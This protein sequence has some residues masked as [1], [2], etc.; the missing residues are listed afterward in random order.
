MK[1]KNVVI[2]ILIFIALLSFSCRKDKAESEVFSSNWSASVD[3]T[4]VGPDFWA[5]RLQDWR[6]KSGRLECLSTR[7]MR[8][9]HLLTRRLEERQGFFR[10]QVRIGWAS[11]RQANGDTA[12][13]IL[14]GAGADLDYRAASLIHHSYGKSGGLFAGVDGQGR[15]FIR[16]FEKAEEFLCHADE[17]SPSWIEIELHLS[18]EP[19]G[20]DYRLKMSAKDI[21]TG[22]EIASLKYSP[23]PPGRV[24]GCLAL[25]SHAGED[26]EN[27]GRFRFSD[28]R[29]SGSKV[30]AYPERNCGPVLST[31]YTLSR[32]T[33][34]LT[35]QM[36]PLGQNDHQT[37][38]LQLKEEDTWNTIAE[39]QIENPGFI[40]PFKLEKWDS[41][42]DREYRIAYD[43]KLGEVD[44]T[45]FWQG[46]IRRDPIEK[47]EIALAAFACNQH[48]VKPDRLDW[49]GVDKGDFPWDW[50]VWFP[51]RDLVEHVRQHRP[52]VLFFSG[53]QIYEGASPTTPDFEKPFLDYLYKWYLWCLTFR[54]LTAE[55]PAITIPDDH[56]VY[57]GNLWGAAGKATDP[58]LSGAEAQ[59]TGGYKMPPEFVNMVQRTQTSHLPDPFDP[60][61]VKNNIGV[62]YT[63]CQVGGLSM[64]V[65]ED[66]KFKSPP[67][68]LL[69]QGE[70]FNG[71][72][73]NNEFDPKKDARIP[74]AS[75]LG[76]R[77]LQFL[78]EWAEDW[79]EQIW[80]KAVLSQTIFINLATLP[81]AAKNDGVV[82]SLA[83]PE[84]GEYVEG[85]RIVSDMDSNGWPQIGREKAVRKIRK[86]FAV[87]IAGDQ[88]LG[89][90]THYGIEDFRDSNVAICTPAV[91]NIFPRR[92]FP[93]YR[94]KNQKPGAPKYTGDYEDGFGNKMT[95]YAVANPRQT[96]RFPSRLHELVTGYSIIRFHKTTRNF[97]LAVWPYWAE[98]GRDEPFQGWP[99]T[100]NQLDNYGRAAKAYL[101]AI[102][103][104]GMQDP[105]IQVIQ[106][107][108][109][110][111]VY[112]LRISGTDF[113]PKVFKMGTYTLKVGDPDLNQIKVFE[114]LIAGSRDQVEFLDVYFEQE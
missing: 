66:R 96:Q 53:D 101:P 48:V 37:V 100:F 16:D 28:W 10:S 25:V 19:D 74:H 70:I 92:W 8:T 114:G 72:P 90:T 73:Q 30:D 11:A 52:D 87:H 89:S 40:A 4:W 69:P 14:F 63:H 7:P 17:G 104:Y 64:A 82:P 94:G 108:T 106:E 41:S 22:K 13:G 6:V 42:Q 55:I 107:S 62:Y 39:V 102:R 46:T 2:L 56:D 83:I 78:E 86:A 79:S 5:N 3:R 59:D 9:V 47:E 38:G 54:E 21:E 57:H 18:V 93:P 58:G 33:L 81:Q 95:V 80:M 51:H 61:P 99:L 77:Q 26:T 45:Y 109:R 36:M 76:D 50:G 91:G 67:K 27:T 68:M 24:A 12:A 85:D 112:T 65:L 71:W 113:Q 35:A 20:N 98:P 111:V 43:L 23:L 84:P 103:V 105:V 29:V 1:N 49:R 32:K 88:H 31:Q 110:K 34:K 60:T 15:L 75:L 44:K 97:E